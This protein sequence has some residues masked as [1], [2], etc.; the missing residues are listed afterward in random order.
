MG[1]HVA[2]RIQPSGVRTLFPT[3]ARDQIWVDRLG[4][5]RSYLLDHL[6]NPHLINF[7]VFIYV[8]VLLCRCTCLYRYVHMHMCVCVHVV[9]RGKLWVSFHRCHPCFV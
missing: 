9:V 4:R 2:V 7:H 8:H 6:T 5:R 1:T 3:G